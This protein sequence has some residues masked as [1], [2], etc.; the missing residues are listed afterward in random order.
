MQAIQL[1]RALL[2][3]LIAV[4]AACG[5]QANELSGSI[6]ETHPLAFDEVRIVRQGD[7]L[8]IEYARPAPEGTFWV[9]KLTI[10]TAGL[11]LGD[12]TEIERAMLLEKTVLERTASTPDEKFPLMSG[13]YLRFYQFGTEGGD[14]VDGEFTVTFENGR[15]L[16][17]VF[18]G[19]LAVEAEST[20]VDQGASQVTHASGAAVALEGS[21]CAQA[22]RGSLLSLVAIALVGKRRQASR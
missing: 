19:N 15:I 22:G 16:S 9:A 6:A 10:A 7:D 1:K 13:G 12:D 3:S 20:G 17:G 11:T 2:L 14:P 4:Q 8:R 5:S 21:S 18:S